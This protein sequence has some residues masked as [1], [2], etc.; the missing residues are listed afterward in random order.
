MIVYSTPYNPDIDLNPVAVSGYLKLQEAWING[1]VPSD[2]VS[3][4]ESYN[5][6]DDPSEIAGKP[7]DFADAYRMNK[8]YAKSLESVNNDKQT[9]SQ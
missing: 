8:E 1:A 2:L 4:A 3:S 6:I 7:R 5:G 9:D